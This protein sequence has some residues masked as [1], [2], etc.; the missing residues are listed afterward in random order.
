MRN[1]QY[2]KYYDNKFM[3]EYNKYK[4]KKNDEITDIPHIYSIPIDKRKILHHLEVYTIDSEDCEDADDAFSIAMNRKTKNLYLYIHISDPTE[5]IN[6]KSK[7]WKQICQQG[8]TIY[9]SNREPIHMM[10]EEI[11]LKANLRETY[12]NKSYKNAITIK[13]NIDTKTYNVNMKDIDIIPSRIKIKKENAYTYKKAGQ[14]LKE[15][16]VFKVGNKIAKKLRQERGSYVGKMTEVN[17]AYP[18]YDKKNKLVKLYLDSEEEVKTKQMIA[19][20]AILANNIVAKYIS[21]N[22]KEK[23]NIYRSCE[24]KNGDK[25]NMKNKNWNEIIEYIVSNGVRACYNTLKTNHDLVEKKFY[26]HFT[27][28]LRRANDCV[29]HYILKYLMIKKENDKVIFPFKKDYINSLMEYCNE[30]NQKIKKM[31]YNDIKYRTIQAMDNILYMKAFNNMYQ[32][33]TIAIKFKIRSYSGIFLN[34]NL[35]QIDKYPVYLMMT[36]KRQF[37]NDVKINNLIKN[38]VIID[39][40]ITTMF[41]QESVLDAGK[42][43]ELEQ[44]LTLYLK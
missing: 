26:V 41:F 40:T 9:P 18:I 43:P 8:Y 44:F 10:P 13:V 23:H 25:Q 29:C 7:I 33:S 24:L 27:S 20:F 2:E 37:L 6:V 4:V 38:K 28:P 32:P 35:I 36:F 5:Y 22:L 12:R 16:K 3:Y 1:E 15:K 30:V 39:G 31:Q 17:N 19:E 14:L 11:L 42:F 21:N 34:I